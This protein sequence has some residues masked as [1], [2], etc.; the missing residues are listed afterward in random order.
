MKEDPNSLIMAL[1]FNYLNVFVVRT[2]KNLCDVIKLDG[3]ITDGMTKD[4]SN[5]HYD[6]MLATYCRNRCHPDD[7]SFF[8]Q[9]LCNESLIK[10][11]ADGRDQIEITYRALVD[12]EIHYYT[13][14]YT[15]ISQPQETLK[16]VAGFRN[17]DSLVE[18]ENKQKQALEQALKAAKVANEAK[19]NFLSNMSHDIRTPMNA[20]VGF[21]EL[22]KPLVKNDKKASEYV[23]KILFSTDYLLNQKCH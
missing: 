3:Y 1:A 2:D 11:F 16:L 4:S 7:R 20:I 8:Y 10:A 9:R 5:L 23:R 15:R 19:T 17:I 21:T 13:G 22:L 18:S 6:N 14:N 12:G